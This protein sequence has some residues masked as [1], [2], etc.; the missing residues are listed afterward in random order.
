M[1][2]RERL[3]GLIMLS[4]T[5]LSCGCP[6][7]TEMLVSRKKCGVL[8]GQLSCGG[9]T[10]TV[11][12][13]P[14]PGSVCN[15]RS[16]FGVVF[17]NSRSS[18]IDL[19]GLTRRVHGGCYRFLRFLKALF[20]GSLGRGNL[21]YSGS[22]L[23]SFLRSVVRY[24]RTVALD[25]DCPLCMHV[26]MINDPYGL[27]AAFGRRGVAGG[28]VGIY[29]SRMNGLIFGTLRRRLGMEGGASSV[30]T[31]RGVPRGQLRSRREGPV[32]SFRTVAG[33]P[34]LRSVR[35]V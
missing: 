3:P 12:S 27:G 25:V 9:F 21:H 15:Q 35:A 16:P 18:L 33:A 13:V 20:M 23:A 24:G 6:G 4:S 1:R 29:F 19:S 30:D 22:E 2:R 14:N 31:R 11:E 7:R 8:C 34:G 5:A 10:L 17:V 26:L 32:L 28:R